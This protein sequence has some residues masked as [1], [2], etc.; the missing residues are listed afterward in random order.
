MN[1]LFF[2]LFLLFFNLQ[3]LS[4][5]AKNN[6]TKKEV[7]KLFYEKKYSLMEINL[8]KLNEVVENEPEIAGNL[9]LAYFQQK[10]YKEAKNIYIKLTNSNNIQVALEAEF[11]LG[12]INTFEGDSLNAITNFERAL[13]KDYKYNLARYNLTL[14]KKL[15]RPKMDKTNSKQNQ[16]K[17]EIE[18]SKVNQG[19]L[20]QLSER[21][22]IL[23]RLNKINLTESQ[24]KNIFETLNNTET[25]YIQQRKVKTSS[26]GNFQ[27]W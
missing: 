22:Q 23:A 19:V 18:N 8:Q 5:V 13:R 21:E 10:K 26:S 12:L 2:E 17:I 4:E 11:H 27:T 3:N 25:K 20:D 15:Y 1:N 16:N 6:Y 24:I 9:G 7:T 14:L